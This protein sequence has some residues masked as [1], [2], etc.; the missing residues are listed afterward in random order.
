MSIKFNDWVKDYCVL[1]KDPKLV[2]RAEELGWRNFIF[3]EK[4]EFD[5]DEIT[6]I[7]RMHK[8][9]IKF[10]FDTKKQSGFRTLGQV[11]EGLNIY[12]SSFNPNGF[13]IDENKNVETMDDV[14]EFLPKII[15]PME[16]KMIREG[17]LC[18][19]STTFL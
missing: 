11:K 18:H 12:V 9:I 10:Y 13:F 2:G 8:N 4:D 7:I 15:N 14:I 19:V 3:F 6:E 16:I 1:V 5:D 17:L